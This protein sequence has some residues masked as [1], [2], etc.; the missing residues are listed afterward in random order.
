M[1]LLLFVESFSSA[2][3]VAIGSFVFGRNIVDG[4]VSGCTVIG[5]F[6]S[7][8]FVIGE[9]V[10]TGNVVSGITKHQK[11]FILNYSNGIFDFFPFCFIEIRTR[12][13]A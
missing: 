7:S 5:G 1:D 9:V 11:D 10:S 12:N 6:V 8:G 4:V 3:E 2:V 13:S